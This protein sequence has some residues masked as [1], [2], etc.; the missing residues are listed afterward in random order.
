M[1]ILLFSTVAMQLFPDYVRDLQWVWECKDMECAM[2]HT[3]SKKEDILLA[4]LYR[5]RRGDA[6]NATKLLHRLDTEYDRAQRA[7]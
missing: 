3:K 1:F 5:N 2:S 7:G 4:F 6:L